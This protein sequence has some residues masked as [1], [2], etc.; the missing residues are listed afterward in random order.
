MAT[1]AFRAKR[2]RGAWQTGQ[3]MNKSSVPQLGNSSPQVWGKGDKTIET[4]HPQLRSDHP[5]GLSA[6][7]DGPH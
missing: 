1:T 7:R 2:Q 3:R 6:R 4:E 5:F